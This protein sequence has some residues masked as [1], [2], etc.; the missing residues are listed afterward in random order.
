MLLQHFIVSRNSPTQEA[1]M[2]KIF[3]V[4]RNRATGINVVVSENARS[5]R[6][7][8]STTSACV[9]PRPLTVSV[10][11]MTAL[12]FTAVAIGASLHTGIARAGGMCNTTAGISAGSA[13]PPGWVLGTICG[14]PTGG[15]PSGTNYSTNDGVWLASLATSIVANGTTNQIYFTIAGAS[16]TLS[17]GVGGLT[18][19]GLANGAVSAT[20]KQAV[21]GQQLFSLSTSASTTNS[22]LASLS[23]G[24]GLSIGSLST[25]PTR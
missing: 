12:V 22:N 11:K 19:D 10:R 4:M 20:S 24:V 17:T 9:G 25:G 1:S 23:T 2:N 8:S 16:V 7:V 21:T 14:A 13:T 5:R 3:K 15:W 6:V 18:M